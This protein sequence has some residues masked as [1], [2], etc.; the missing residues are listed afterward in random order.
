MKPNAIRL[1]E[2][3][4]NGYFITH[5]EMQE[6]AKEIRELYADAQRYRWLNKNTAHLFH[7]TQTDLD[8]QV[9]RAIGGK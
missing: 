1:A 8:E 6:A 5:E 9:D 4:E 3:L 2:L 7:C